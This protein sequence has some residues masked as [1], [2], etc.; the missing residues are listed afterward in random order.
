M[1]HCYCTFHV[2][3]LLLGIAVERVAEVL[4]GCTITPL[5]LA[6]ADVAGLLNLRG[7]VV[8]AIDARHRLGLADRDDDTPPTIVV[9]RSDGEAIGLLVDHEDDFVDVGQSHREELPETVSAAVRALVLGAFQIAGDE[10]LLV[11]DPDRM[12]AVAS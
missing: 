10:L 6:R 7:Q 4:R 11:L 12:L 5:P 9:I 1:K 8:T 2:D 3:G